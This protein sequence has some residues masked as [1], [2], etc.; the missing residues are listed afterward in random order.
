MYTVYLDVY[1]CT[2]I[3]I[4]VDIRYIY[5]IYIVNEDKKTHPVSTEKLTLD[6][7]NVMFCGI[8][9]IIV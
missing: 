7:A 2:D 9:L 3:Y 5:T 1:I 4:Y 6:R 8:T